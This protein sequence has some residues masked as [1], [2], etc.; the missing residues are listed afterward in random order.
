[1]L[2]FSSLL[3]VPVYGL[4]SQYSDRSQ[5]GQQGLDSQ[6]GDEILS[7]LHSDETDSGDHPAYPM[8]SRSSFLRDK[9]ARA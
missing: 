3:Y 6:L 2:F 1:M 8:G 9:V 7:L 5:A 4:L